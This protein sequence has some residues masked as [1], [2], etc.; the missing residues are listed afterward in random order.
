MS[1]RLGTACTTVVTFL[2]FSKGK[3][4]KAVKILALHLKLVVL[5]IILVNIGSVSLGLGLRIHWQPWV[6]GHLVILKCKGS[7]EA[8]TLCYL[9]SL[10]ARLKTSC[11]IDCKSGLIKIKINR[12]LYTMWLWK[13]ICRWT[14]KRVTKNNFEFFNF[15]SCA[16]TCYTQKVGTDF[17]NKTV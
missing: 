4:V 16:S 15:E 17:L 6:W 3:Q 11:A 2:I 13:Q 14:V 1:S 12:P 7:A 10:F 8:S 9:Q 5:N